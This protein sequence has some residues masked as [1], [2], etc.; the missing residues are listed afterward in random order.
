[1]A[2]YGALAK[3]NHL[4]EFGEP[5]DTQEG[6][7]TPATRRARVAANLTGAAVDPAGFLDVAVNVLMPDVS[8]A[9]SVARVVSPINGQVIGAWAVISGALS[10]ADAELELSVA[11]SPEFATITLEQEDSA[12]GDAFGVDAPITEN[13][14]VNVGDVIV[15]D[16]D[17]AS[18]G[19]VTAQMTILIR[20]TA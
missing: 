18:T 9:S 10:A 4:S 14:N 15:V 5:L 1:M 11:G 17:G 19:T 2:L 7:L 20:R 12:A 6:V 13:N 3:E 8:T 16:T